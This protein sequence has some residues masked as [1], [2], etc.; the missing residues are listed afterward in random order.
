M[1]ITETERDPFSCRLV[2]DVAFYLDIII[3]ISSTLALKSL[4]KNNIRQ[5]NISNVYGEFHAQHIC[6]NGHF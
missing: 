2:D 5:S 1:L 4:K 3:K 6:T